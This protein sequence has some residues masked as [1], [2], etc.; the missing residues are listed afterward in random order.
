MADKKQERIDYDAA[1]RA[2]FDKFPIYERVYVE[3]TV[4]R[5]EICGLY[6]KPGLSHKCRKRKE[7][8][9]GTE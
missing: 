6:Y 7:G 1:T 9:H 8:T 4:M 5:C 3:T 2:W